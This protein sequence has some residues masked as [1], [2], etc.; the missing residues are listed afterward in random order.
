MVATRDI[1]EAAAAKLVDDTWIGRNVMGL[2]GP[3]DLT[4]DEAVKILGVVAGRPLRNIQITP[5]EF[6]KVSRG[7][8]ASHDFAENYIEMFETFR[9]L[10]W[11]YLDEPRTPAT[12]TPTTLG[13][14][15]SQVLIPL[16]KVA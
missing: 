2:H 1:A 14:W 8:G 7:W 12:T 11:N 16:V 13:A 4:V 3:T 15:A 10:G 9:R 6:R 5:D